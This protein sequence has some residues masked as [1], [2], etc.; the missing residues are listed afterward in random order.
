MNNQHFHLFRNYVAI[1][2][3]YNKSNLPAIIVVQGMLN[4]VIKTKSS[5]NNSGVV[6]HPLAPKSYPFIFIHLS[7]LLFIELIF[8]P[9]FKI[10]HTSS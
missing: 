7:F 2:Q 8:I 6:D 3:R 9:K 5:S 4:H 10:L 1:M